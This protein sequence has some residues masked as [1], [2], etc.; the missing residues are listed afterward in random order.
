MLYENSFNDNSKIMQNVGPGP[1]KAHRSVILL[2]EE[3]RK[4][5]SLVQYSYY[6]NMQKSPLPNIVARVEAAVAKKLDSS[7]FD[8]VG[9]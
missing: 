2:H 9:G 7:N 5:R 4:N 8:V 6:E 1:F 3:P